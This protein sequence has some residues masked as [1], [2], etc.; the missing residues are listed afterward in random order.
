MFLI[1]SWSIVCI[2]KYISVWNWTPVTYYK[3]NL[4]LVNQEF[5]KTQ[6]KVLHNIILI[7]CCQFG[8]LFDCWYSSA[9]SLFLDEKSYTILLDCNLNSNDP[10][11]FIFHENRFFNI[12]LKVNY[13][14]PELKNNLENRRNFSADFWN[15]HKPKIKKSLLEYNNCLS[16]DFKELAVLIPVVELL[17]EIKVS[18]WKLLPELWVKLM[19]L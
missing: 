9:S 12:N 6:L 16:L 15:Q 11:R 19:I 17:Q 8:R 10:I 13:P 4:K 7:T 18:P 3:Y 14:L 5:Y 1:I 2:L